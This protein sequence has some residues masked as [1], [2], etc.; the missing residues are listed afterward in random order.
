MSIFKFIHGANLALPILM[1]LLLVASQVAV[2]M[3]IGAFI[4]S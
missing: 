3:Q 2:R 1:I 4:R